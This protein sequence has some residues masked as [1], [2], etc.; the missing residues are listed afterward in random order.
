MRR[1]PPAQVAVPS[2]AVG[3]AAANG[4]RLHGALD[5]A[6]SA[7]LVAVAAFLLPVPGKVL[8]AAAGACLAGWAWGTARLDTLDRS[9]LLADVD[10][11]GRALIE[12]TGEGRRGAF[13]LRMPGR[14]HRFE[15]RPVGERVQLELPLGRAPPQGA[16]VAALVVVRLPRASSHGFDER[17]WLRRQGVHVVLKVDEWKIVGHRGGI[18]GVADRLRGWLRSDATPGLTGQR[19]AVIAGVVLGDDAALSPGLQES[20]RRS[21]LYHLLKM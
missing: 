18:G 21:G 2:A 17:R 19:R 13:E 3:L 6:T 10:R 8:L 9:P 4:L 16:L 20:F 7:G 5:V 1:L 11:S 15:G 14:M 12:I